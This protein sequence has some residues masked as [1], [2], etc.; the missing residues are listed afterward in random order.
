MYALFLLPLL[1]FLLMLALWIKGAM[2]GE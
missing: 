2:E 1:S